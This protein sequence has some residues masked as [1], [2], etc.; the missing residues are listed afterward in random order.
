MID[1]IPPQ[2]RL[3]ALAV[4][5]ALLI[6]SGWCAQGWR[7]GEQM[8]QMET[9]Q[10][11]AL[12]NAQ[13][14]ARAKEKQWQDSLEE[15][16]NDAQQSIEVATADAAAAAATADSLQQ[17]VDRLAR[18]PARCPAV[19]DGSEA[20]DPAGLLLADLLRRINERAGQ[21]A[22]YADRAR[23]AGVACEKSYGVLR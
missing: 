11:L 22:A 4:V 1:L 23:I 9:D 16:R 12:A 6:Y 13:Q 19:A 10:A 21:L 3:I 7:L 2:L 17:Q 18:R 20:A 15:T 14:Q 5:A 8:A